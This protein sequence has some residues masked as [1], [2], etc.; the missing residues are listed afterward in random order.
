M[1]VFVA[2]NLNRGASVAVESLSVR[3]S[4]HN[5]VTVER[6]TPMQWFDTYIEPGVFQRHTQF[7][8]RR[9]VLRAIGNPAGCTQEKF[10][11][12]GD[13]ETPVR[14]AQH[15][16]DDK[17]A[18]WC[19]V[20]DRRLQQRRLPLG[21]QVVQHVEQG[22]GPCSAGSSAAAAWCKLIMPSSPARRAACCPAAILRSS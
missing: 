10:P 19:Q 12:P 11:Q 3:R 20:S 9:I 13:M 2:V 1:P 22:D 21:W 14:F 17:T 6:R 18:L 8:G 16:A 15:V 5:Q 4:R 7:V